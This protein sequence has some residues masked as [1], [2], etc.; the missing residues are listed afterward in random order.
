MNNILLGALLIGL[1]EC[2]CS[3][4]FKNKFKVW[5][6]CTLTQK[7]AKLCST[8]HGYI[9]IYIFILTSLIT[10]AFLTTTMWSTEDINPHE[11]D[12]RGDAQTWASHDK[13][14]PFL[15]VVCVF[16]CEERLS[17]PGSVFCL[18]VALKSVCLQHEEFGFDFN[19]V[20]IEMV[21]FD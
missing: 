10:I 1:L 8:A 18:G 13:T 20:C 14:I 15:S 6:Y 5:T 4:T 17:H 11:T 21:W 19:C 12:L 3:L 7:A 9:Y 2:L 16:C